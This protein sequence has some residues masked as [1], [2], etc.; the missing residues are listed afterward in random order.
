MNTIITNEDY[1]ELL[2]NQKVNEFKLVAWIM[3]GVAIFIL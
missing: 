3:L 2:K 1:R